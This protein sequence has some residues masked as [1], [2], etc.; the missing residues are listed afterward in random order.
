[1]NSKTDE[2]LA[3]L[4][5]TD[6]SASAVLISRFSKLIFI[7]S[8]IYAN[9]ETD[10]DDLYQEGMISLLKAIEAFNPK[11]GVKFSTF[12]EVCI[13]NRMRT[14][15]KKSVRDFSFAERIDDEEAADVLSDEETPES[16]YF[17]KEFFSELW[18]DIC[19]VLSLTELNVLTL[20]VQGMSY[21]D[22]AEKLEMTEK[23]VDNAMQ[24]ARRK[25]RALMHDTN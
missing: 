12:A 23:S 9:S 10:S 22:A 3:V 24:R 2:E 20:C 21:R 4:G 5:K 1:M 19:S 18:K 25:I 6:K 15:S 7:K 14:V 11:K 17:Y 16:I 13:V 8:E